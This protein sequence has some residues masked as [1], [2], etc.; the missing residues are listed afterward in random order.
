MSYRSLLV[1]IAATTCISPALADKRP[2][3]EVG[4]GAVGGY[5]PTYWGSSESS[6]MGFP[7]IYFIYRGEDF[8][9]LPNGLGF[10]DVENTERFDFGL[11]VDFSGGIDSEDRLGY[12]DIDFVGEVGPEV[13]FGLYSTGESRLQ[14]RIGARAAFELGEG[15]TGVVIEPELAFVTK[16]SDTTRIGVSIAPRFAFDGYNQL[17]YGT[18]SFTAEDGYIGTDIGFEASYDLSDR[19][20]IIGDVHAIA[21]S[22]AANE[23]SPLYQEDWNVDARIGFTYAFWQSDEMTAD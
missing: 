13:T 5:G 6:A 17:F 20:R 22:G 18:P 1:L 15:Y 4:V 9:F 23:D 12:G 19:W 10:I 8:S 21:L 16:V 7:F 3:W 14:L 11:S 2:V